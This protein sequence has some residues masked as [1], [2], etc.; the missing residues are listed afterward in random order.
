MR[1]HKLFIKLRIQNNLEKFTFEDLNLQ[2]TLE[3]FS[4]IFQTAEAHK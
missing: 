2:S 3:R 1:G 4:I